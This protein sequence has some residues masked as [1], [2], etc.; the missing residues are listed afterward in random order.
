[1]NRVSSLRPSINVP[2]RLRSVAGDILSLHR[3]KF[4]RVTVLIGDEPLL[5]T[6][7]SRTVMALVE[8][9]HALGAS[10]DLG[11]YWLHDRK[12]HIPVVLFRLNSIDVTIAYTVPLLER[13]LY[14]DFHKQ[15][16]LVDLL[17]QD[18]A[19]S[20][21][22]ESGR[23]IPIS[24]AEKLDRALVEDTRFPPTLALLSDRG[25]VAEISLA[26]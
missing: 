13:R 3:G 22:R 24:L 8:L 25:I 10:F 23:S 17:V 12:C 21:P 7:R 5:L 4:R 9:A 18:G 19:V 14:E 6:V 2:L 1:M 26:R 15:L 20:R 16:P 11:A